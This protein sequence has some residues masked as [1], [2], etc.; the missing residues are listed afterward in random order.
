MKMEWRRIKWA[1]QSGRIE[2]GRVEKENGRGERE[3]MGRWDYHDVSTCRE[4]SGNLDI[5][6]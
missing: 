2:E 3:E 6:E 4:R 5:I 1:G